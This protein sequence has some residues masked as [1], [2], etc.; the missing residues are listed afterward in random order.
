[1]SPTFSPIRNRL[2]IGILLT[3]SVVTS[4]VIMASF[5]L[6]YLNEKDIL[7]LVFSQIEKG[8]V[9][10]L[11]TAIWNYNED[12]IKSQLEGI[13][14]INDIVK[15]AVQDDKGTLLFETQK[16]SIDETLSL[17]KQFDI[18]FE[19]QNEIKNVGILK[20]TA[21]RANMFKR[22][23]SKLFYFT[24]SQ[25]GK[26]LL[27]S[28][29]ISIIIKKLVANNIYRMKIF[30]ENYDPS[31][32]DSNARTLNLKQRGK[33][34]DEFDILSHKITEMSLENMKH[35]LESQDR[36]R[37]EADLNAATLVQQALFPDVAI[38]PGFN[39]QSSYKPASKAGGD[40]YL[41][42]FD[43]IQQRAHFYI[44]DVTGH[45]FP[46]ALVTGVASGAIFALRQHLSKIIDTDNTINIDKHLIFLATELNSIIFKIGK[47]QYGMTMILLS[48][49]VHTG[50]VSLLNAGHCH[51]FHIHSGDTKVSNMLSKG[52]RIGFNE[53]VNFNV[54]SFQLK[55]NDGIFM[56]TDGLFE[57][58]AEESDSLLQKEVIKILA[59]GLKDDCSETHDS[60]IHLAKK[61]WGNSALQDDVATLLL[62]WQGPIKGTIQGPIQVTERHKFG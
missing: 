53:V 45:G 22:L 4:V 3:S 42:H 52:P 60:V 47:G 31:S 54:K 12:Q 1:M 6:D 41:F 46:A 21:T 33:H 15:V 34:I 29:I 36:V 30:F 23:R 62:R 50:I 39:I 5:Y 57:N 49:D 19:F 48:I 25:L 38:L 26:T 7:D 58:S 28:F 18:T 14:K 59:R 10:P 2:L 20:V 51:P 37:E 56:Y 43:E 13:I 11:G 44:G 24:F 35:L 17:Q 55:P 40:W 61:Y 16:A 32:L 9:S 8:N 27:I